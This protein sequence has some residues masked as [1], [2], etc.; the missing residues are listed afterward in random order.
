MTV[1]LPVGTATVKATVQ[2]TVV[3]EVA[4]VGAQAIDDKAGW[5][6]TGTVTRLLRKSFCA[7]YSWAYCPV[8]NEASNCRYT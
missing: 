7:M 3:P 2:V 4:V 5:F 1:V 6:S 8:V